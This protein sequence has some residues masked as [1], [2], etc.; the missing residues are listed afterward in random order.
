MCYFDWH[1]KLLYQV[2]GDQSLALNFQFFSF[3]NKF[4]ILVVNLVLTFLAVALNQIRNTHKIIF[5]TELRI[6]CSL[7]LNDVSVYGSPQP[8]QFCV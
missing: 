1:K 5:L 4:D 7:I 6:F 2:Y 3:R 8:R